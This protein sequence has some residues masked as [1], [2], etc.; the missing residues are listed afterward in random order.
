MVKIFIS[1][2]NRGPIRSAHRF[3]LKCPMCGI[4][5]FSGVAPSVEDAIIR[6]LASWF[7]TNLSSQDS[8]NRTCDPFV[9]SCIEIELDYISPMEAIATESDD[10][11][12]KKLSEVLTDQ[13]VFGMPRCTFKWG[14]SQCWGAR[15][16]IGDHSFKCN[17]S[18]CPGYAWPVSEKPHPISTCGEEAKEEE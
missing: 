5:P 4:K 11:N 6:C 1:Y 7:A 9:E 18:N 2:K 13:M 15:N 10:K 12:P 17:S 14:S 16:H 3:A 8:F